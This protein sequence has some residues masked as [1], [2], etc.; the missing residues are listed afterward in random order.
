MVLPANRPGYCPR[1][2]KGPK[3]PRAACQKPEKKPGSSA[4]HENRKENK[5]AAAAPYLRRGPPSG[6]R[7][8]RPYASGRELYP[9][10]RTEAAPRFRDERKRKKGKRLPACS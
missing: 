5:K 8:A 10:P 4:T 2:S 7:A 3:G 9:R 6:D 1:P